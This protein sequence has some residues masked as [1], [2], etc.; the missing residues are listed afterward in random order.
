MQ[1]LGI[2]LTSFF[3]V[4]ALSIYGQKDS[5]LIKKHNP[6]FVL[7]NDSV[8]TFGGTRIATK[9][10]T[11]EFHKL[12]LS[13]YVSSYYA[14]YSDEIENS[15]F[16][17][18][19]TMAPRNDQF[20]L[21]IAQIGMQ[22]QDQNFRGNI[23]LHYGD[24][25]ESNWP[26]P[27]T[28]IQE[29]HAGFKLVKNLWLD[30]GFFK[31]HIGIESVQPRE[32]ITSSMAVISYYE[33]YFLSGA[34]L[35]Y[36]ATNK[37]S[38][39][40]N[41]FNGYNEYVENNKNK[42]LG[43]S[44]LYEFNKNFSITY[45][46]L[47]CDETPDNVKTKHQRIFHNLYGNFSTKKFSLGAEVNHGTQKNSALRDTSLTASMFSGLVVAKYQM[48]KKLGVYTRGEY[49][50]DKNRIFTGNLDLGNYIT[51]ITGGVEFKPI[52]NAALSTEYRLLECDNLI[53]KE[54]N[55]LTNQRHELIICL[56]VW[57]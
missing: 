48:L 10:D 56:D 26:K 7:S 13:A 46:V 8:V 25:P 51:G 44:A 53:F 43:F 16:V 1:R 52:K 40:L 55:T 14:H 20:G 38:L 6:I 21:N 41:I 12:E 32:N 22:Y 24:I 50:S 31:T 2:F 18:F 49:Y 9:T 42:A 36:Q 30:A 5:V 27:F 54:G 47:T 35:T 17:Q 33:P 4:I 37:L 3:F 39:Q 23:T 19:P 11:A 34:K 45:N 28:L 15:G 57:F 29:A